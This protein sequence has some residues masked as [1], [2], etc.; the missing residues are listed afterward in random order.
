LFLAVWIA[1][2]VVVVRAGRHAFDA[3]PFILLN[4]LLFCLAAMQGAI[5]LIA[6]RRADQISSEL[7]AHDYAVNRRAETLI[8]ENTELTR[9]IKDLAE[10]THHQVVNVA[11]PTNRPVQT[12]R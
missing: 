4:L 3:Y 2:N 5:L 7:A 9:I 10:A 12:G 1:V 11:P 6:A 8:E